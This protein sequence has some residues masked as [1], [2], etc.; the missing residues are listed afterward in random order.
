MITVDYSIQA[1][2]KLLGDQAK[3]MAKASKK[4]EAQVNKTL[5]CFVFHDVFPSFS[6]SPPFSFS[7]FLPPSFSLPSFSLSPPFSFSLFLPLSFYLPFS[8]SLSPSFL[9]C[10]RL[11][12]LRQHTRHNLMISPRV[13]RT[14]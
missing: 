8:L 7:L 13:R 5:M 3:A 1:T 9:L 11:R 10:F 2:K 14:K 4:G 12:N 6:L